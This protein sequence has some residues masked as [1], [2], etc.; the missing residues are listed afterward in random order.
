MSLSYVLI[1]DDTPDVRTLM[2]LMVQALGYA[3]VCVAGAEAALAAC[4]NSE[5]LPFLVFMDL[6][7]PGMGGTEA[8]QALR[9]ADRTRS[10]P[11]VCV[12][13]EAFDAD[14]MLAIGFTSCIRK[15]FARHQLAA[16]LQAAGNSST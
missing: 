13:A 6:H 16:A 9:R 2:A 14:A 8:V 7:M 11:V 12:S 4:R 15:P 1:V 3:T 10:L 5:D